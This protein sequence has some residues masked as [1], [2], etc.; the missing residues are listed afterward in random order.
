LSTDQLVGL[1]CLNFLLIPSITFIGEY[2]Y[3]VNIGFLM[4]L[5]LRRTFVLLQQ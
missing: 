5:L 1:N 2:F 4:M 3:V